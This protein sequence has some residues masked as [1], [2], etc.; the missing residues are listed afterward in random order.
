MA[1]VA[2][3]EAPTWSDEQV[4]LDLY[5]AADNGKLDEV[6]RLLPLATE[7]GVVDKVMHGVNTTET[8][9][10]LPVTMPRLSHLVPCL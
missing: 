4:C 1:S 2:D 9:E 5:N 6:T 3:S 8:R 7:K 10:I